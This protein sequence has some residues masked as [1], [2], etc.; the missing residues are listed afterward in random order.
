M[1]FVW[2]HAS[3]QPSFLDVSWR[4]PE[5]IWKGSVNI[6]PRSLWSWCSLMWQKGLQR[7]HWQRASTLLLR[8]LVSSGL[9]QAR[10]GCS[11]F[12]LQ[13]HLW[14]DKS[15]WRPACHCLLLN[16]YSCYAQ[17]PP[18]AHTQLLQG[19]Q[20]HWGAILAGVLKGIFNRVS[21]ESLN[22]HPR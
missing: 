22:P 11:F 21:R 5:R 16:C 1:E 15:D 10:K 13:S 14:L 18:F 4:K 2:A 7:T 8:S 19:F 9:N 3:E 12:S 17:T 6:R 20:V